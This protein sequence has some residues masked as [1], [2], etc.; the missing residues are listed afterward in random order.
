MKA[1]DWSASGRLMQSS[2]NNRNKKKCNQYLQMSSFLLS[3]QR[4]NRTGGNQNAG[5]YRIFKGAAKIFSE[6]L[7]DYAFT[8]YKNM[9]PLHRWLIKAIDN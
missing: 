5:F 8:H 7:I 6:A 4:R 1:S 9:L 3:I 2:G